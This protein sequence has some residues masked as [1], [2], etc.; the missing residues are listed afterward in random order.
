VEYKWTWLAQPEIQTMAQ[1]LMYVGD[2]VRGL[3]NAPTRVLDPAFSIRWT[4]LS[5]ITVREALQALEVRSAAEHV[6]NCLAEVRGERYGLNADKA[7][8]TAATIDEYLKTCWNSADSLHRGFVRNVDSDKAEERLRYVVRIHKREITTLDD[9]WNAFGWAEETDEAIA[10]LTQTLREATS[11]VLLC[12]PGTVL[13]WGKES[14]H[15]PEDITQATPTDF[16]LQFIPPRLLIRR[17]WLCAWALQNISTTGWGTSVYTP[18][19]LTDL[20]APELSEPTMRKLMD[21]RAGPMETQLWRLQDLCAGGLFYTLELFIAAIKSSHKAASRE[22]SREL[23]E[24]TFRV[25]TRKWKEYQCSIWTEMLLVD[26]FELVLPTNNDPSSDQV[27][28][29]IVGLFLTFLSNVLAKKTGPHVQHAISLIKAY[30][31]GPGRSDGVARDV[32]SK[33]ESP[34]T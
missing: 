32:L 28:D 22:S 3:R 1:V 18:K 2:D 15:V 13:T 29:Y 30:S 14:R 19:K 4:C 24:G 5:I 6:I 34:W 20:S 17:L 7:A 9:K 16:M 21:K 12:L 31:E 23:Y 25:I 8:E 27:P 10:K 33:L 11:S 26:L